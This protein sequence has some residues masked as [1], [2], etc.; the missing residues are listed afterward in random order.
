MKVTFE[1]GPSLKESFFVASEE[2]H[3]DEVVRASHVLPRPV[4]SEIERI[5]ASDATKE[6]KEK[7]L[8]AM[9][10]QPEEYVTYL[11][12]TCSTMK[13]FRETCMSL[14]TKNGGLTA[15][16][17]TQ[18][19]G[20]APV[21]AT[22]PGEKVKT[23]EEPVVAAESGYT[24]D[25]GVEME[26]APG[27]RKYYQGLPGKAVGD[28]QR[29]LDMQ[30]SQSPE[31]RVMAEELAKTKGEL[32]DAKGE[33]AKRDKSKDLEGVLETLTEMG[34]IEDAKDRES[35]TKDL[36]GLDEKAL[37]ILEKVLKKVRDAVAGG[38]KKSPAGPPKPPAPAG[39]MP[40][41]PPAA[42]KP[43]GGI[44]PMSASGNL[45]QPAMP[46][47]MAPIQASLNGVDQGQLLTQIWLNDDQ[48]KGIFAR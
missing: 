12:K 14:A 27:V 11:Q 44:P 40:P 34:G 4:V 9:P 29:A 43:P 47:D 22:E 15:V 25:K 28:P 23:G 5:A 17:Q 16:A 42:P 18:K 35:F 20:G 2:G 36:G 19:V 38:A 46:Q 8:A 6:D 45:F 32:A 30:S 48:K 24:G 10:V 21:T 31:V 37:G 13:A 39:A 26:A 7:E 3:D 1:K 41:K 33:I